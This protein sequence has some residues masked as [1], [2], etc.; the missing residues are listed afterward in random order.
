MRAL[1]LAVAAALAVASLSA[2]VPPARA[3]TADVALPSAPVDHYDRS[4]IQRG[5]K[6][7]MN[8]C[9]GCH[10]ARYA[11]YKRIADDLGLTEEQAG[12]LLNGSA[13]LVD[14]V[15]SPMA[16]D[17]ARE[18][19]GQAVPPDLTLVTRV[20]GPDWVYAFLRGYHRDPGTLTGWNNTVFPNTAMPHVLHGLQGVMVLSQG[21][22]GEP[23]G[24]ETAVPGELGPAQYDSLVADLTNFLVY[25]GDPGRNFRIRTG[26]YVLL[27]LLVL[28][29]HTHLL[30]RE[31][32][33]DVK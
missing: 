31:Y 7:F 24:L 28:L 5:A 11:R 8:Y 23:A 6:V 4:S 2:P 18:W 3:A 32:W 29:V 25:M 26:I 1:P 20:R 27:A 33:K 15:E 22:D 21:E 9:I 13:T 19:F 17:D 16:S 14:H 10:G 30:Y 12:A